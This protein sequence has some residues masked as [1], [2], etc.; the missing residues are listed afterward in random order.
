MKTFHNKAISRRFL[1]SATFGIRRVFL[2]LQFSNIIFVVLLF[3]LLASIT[4]G[5][6]S[7]CT[8]KARYRK[9]EQEL[10]Q[11]RTV[12]ESANNRE[13]ELEEQFDKIKN[14]TGESIE[15]VQREH[16]LLI[17]GGTTIRE[18]RA[19]VKDLEEYCDNLEYWLFSIRDNAFTNKIKGDIK[20]DVGNY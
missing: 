5:G 8:Y 3:S 13:R 19:Q 18:I 9:S 6:I 2:C 11:L 14:L 7:S 12:L 15:Y 20:D 17:K 10:G 16:D 1:N 4:I